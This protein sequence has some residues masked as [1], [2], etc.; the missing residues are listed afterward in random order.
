MAASEDA[1]VVAATITEIMA[2]LPRATEQLE[3]DNAAIRDWMVAHAASPVVLEALRDSTWLTLR[4]VEAIGQL[5]PVNGITIARQFGIPKGSVSKITRR[6]VAKRLVVSEKAP[7]NRKEVLY[8]LTPLGSE[9]FSLHHAF[10]RQMERG[11]VRFLERYPPEAL[12][13]LLQLLQDSLHVSILELG[14]D[15]VESQK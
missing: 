9:L 13:A 3:P 10:D 2:T 5:E 14:A 6:L 8:R 15:A 4:V 1:A 7:N 12:R 11:F